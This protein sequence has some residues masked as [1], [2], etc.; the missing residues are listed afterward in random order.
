MISDQIAPKSHQKHWLSPRNVQITPNHAKPK[1]LRPNQTGIQSHQMIL[2][3]ITSTTAK[4]HRSPNHDPELFDVILFSIKAA[5][6][7]PDGEMFTLSVRYQE[8]LMKLIFYG[9][10]CSAVGRTLIGQGSVLLF[11]AN[12]VWLVSRF[13]IFYIMF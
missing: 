7:V 10:R 1:P 12:R 3:Q 5:R 6:Q 9:L 13:Y 2:Y 8:Y 11:N 4:K